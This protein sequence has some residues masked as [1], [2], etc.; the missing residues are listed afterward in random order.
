MHFIFLFELIAIYWVCYCSCF[1]L[2][3]GNRTLSLWRRSLKINFAWFRHKIVIFKHKVVILRHWIVRYRRRIVCLRGLV[4]F[5]TTLLRRI[6]IW[7][8]FSGAPPPLIQRTIRL[9]PGTIRPETMTPT[10]CSVTFNV[11][12]KQYFNIFNFVM[13]FFIFIYNFSFSYGFFYFYA[14]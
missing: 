2:L 14:I 10:P 8:P 4:L 6:H 5:L 3:I 12:F 9:E 1:Y 11:S 7:Q 13:R